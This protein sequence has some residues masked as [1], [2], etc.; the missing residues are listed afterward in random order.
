MLPEYRASHG[1][2]SHHRSRM[3]IPSGVRGQVIPRYR[4]ASIRFDR[5]RGCRIV[6]V[7]HI[8]K[9]GGTAVKTALGRGRRAATRVIPHPHAFTLAD[10]PNGDFCVFFV[11]DPITR[12]VSGFYSR[13]REGRPHYREPWTDGERRAFGTFG[14]PNDLALALSSDQESRRG[15]A[16]RALQSIQHV[17]DSYWRWLKDEAYLAQRRA[18]IL[19]VGAQENLVRDYGQLSEILGMGGELPRS[20]ADAHRNPAG[21]DYGLAGEA[22]ENL[23]QW[24]SREYACLRLLSSWYNHLPKYDE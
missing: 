23:R 16:V 20:D 6:H 4:A 11:R 8:G 7:L 21:L 13:Q 22:V 5:I 1:H 17:K 19:F 18:S 14:T 24:Y 15:E 12:Y 9:T 3:L 2:P 10:V